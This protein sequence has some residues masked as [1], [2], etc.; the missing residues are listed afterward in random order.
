MPKTLKYLGVTI[1]V[2][3]LAVTLAMTFH[4]F[5]TQVQVP[6]EKQVQYQ[7]YETQT[8]LLDHRENYQISAG[9]FAYSNFS[10]EAGKTLKVTW[11]TDSEVSIHILSQTQF[12]TF[13]LLGT[14]YPTLASKRSTPSGS[15]SYQ[16]P[17]TATYYVTINDPNAVITGNIV[18]VGSYKSELQ[19][20]ELVT[21][22]RTETDYRT[23]TVYRNS[24]EGV[25]LG[26]SLSVVG[27]IVTSLGLAN[28]S[29]YLNN[30]KMLIVKIRK[31][32]T[33]TCQYC[34]SEYKKEREECPHCGAR[35]MRK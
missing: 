5:P 10:L 19:W 3:G 21:K 17:A 2:I 15:L 22:Y 35:R 12:S 11:Q 30:A 29:R 27:V 9:H 34:G 18:N 1:F 23:E 16:I 20:Q 14:T 28:L 25:N 26:I 32:N 6:Y 4:Q 33:F 13:K 31:R 8:Q 24:L 7:E